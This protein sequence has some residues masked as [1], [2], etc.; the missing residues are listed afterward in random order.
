MLTQARKQS[1]LS[2]E[3]NPEMSSVEHF[4]HSVPMLIFQGTSDGVTPVSNSKRHFQ[5]SNS[6]QSRLYLI[7]GGGHE[8]YLT[9]LDLDDTSLR[10][11]LEGK[12]DGIPES[13]PAD[14][15]FHDRIVSFGK[16]TPMKNALAWGRGCLWM[17]NSYIGF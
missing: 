13:L 1:K 9:T 15:P 8:D 3:F 11:I 5:S 16:R 6:P 2:P 4:Q 14:S 17:L 12:W 7:H 10:Q